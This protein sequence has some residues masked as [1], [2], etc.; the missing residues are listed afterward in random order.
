MLLS[1]CLSQGKE[2]AREKA[3]ELLAKIENGTALGEFS[4][5]YFPKEQVRSLLDGLRYNCDFKHRKGGFVNDYYT[6]NLNG[7]DRVAVIY[8]YYLKCDSIRL[9]FQYNLGTTPE[10]SGFHAE[11][12]EKENPMVIKSKE[13]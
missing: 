4:P 1:S 2:E 12:I 6:K 11:G 8:E 5:K 9:I 3:E 7:P 13:K 10:L